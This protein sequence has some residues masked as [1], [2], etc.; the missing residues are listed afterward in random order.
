MGC[1]WVGDARRGELQTV[2]LRKRC[3]CSCQQQK[4]IVPEV[5]TAKQCVSKSDVVIVREMVF[6]GRKLLVHTPL[7][8]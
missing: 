2:M 4:V 7:E 5:A 3:V 1:W 6:S 8:L